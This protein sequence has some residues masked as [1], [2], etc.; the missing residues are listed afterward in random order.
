M[1]NFWQANM[2]EATNID[3]IYSTPSMYVDALA[4]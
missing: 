1:I 2:A 3:L 4:A